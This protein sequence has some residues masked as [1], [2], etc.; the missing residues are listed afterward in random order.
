MSNNSNI[1]TINR[2][3]YRA[4]RKDNGEWIHW[5][6]YGEICK[7]NGRKSHLATTKG[8]KTTYY[9]YIYQV[10]HLIVSDTIERVFRL[11]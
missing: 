5:N 9:Y 7:V 8:A 4:K 2:T 10:R 3:I 1:N 11:S 6:V